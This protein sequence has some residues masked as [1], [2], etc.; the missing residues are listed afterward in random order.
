MGLFFNRDAA[1][2]A[3]NTNTNSYLDDQKSLFNTKDNSQKKV[4]DDSY[5]DYVYKPKDY[6]NV[7]KYK[8]HDLKKVDIVV[9]Q[10]D[11]GYEELNPDIKTVN[12][13]KKDLHEDLMELVNN[14]YIDEKNKVNTTSIYDEG[15]NNEI[16]KD[17]NIEIID[18]DD[19][20]TI[21]DIS[22][23][24]VENLNNSKK[25]SIFGSSDEPIKA[26]I[27]EINP[28]DL[29]SKEVVV[30]KKE[31][32]KEEVKINEDGKKVCPN[33]GAPLSLTATTCFLCGTKL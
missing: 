2:A 1:K 15:I 21:P 30:E 13:Q 3:S 20:K 5:D 19:D 6:S 4:V 8:A 17:D 18:I 32:P 23:S 10:N 24:K 31:G 25:L 33:C 26:K 16:K 12:L 7:P 9:D 11:F 29:K 28:E 27:H 14:E 22:A